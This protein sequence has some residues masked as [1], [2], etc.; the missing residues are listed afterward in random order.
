[1]DTSD[2]KRKPDSTDVLPAAGKKFR[3]YVGL[4]VSLNG[5]HYKVTKV[6][7]GGRVQ[8]KEVGR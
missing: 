5:T 1:M 3:P 6:L 7:S 8:M 4:T 2:M